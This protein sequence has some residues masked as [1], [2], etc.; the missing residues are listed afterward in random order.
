MDLVSESET[1]IICSVCQQPN[2]VGTRF[3]HH[4]WGAVLHAGC[5]M[6]TPRQNESRLARLKSQQRAKLITISLLALITLASIIFA[7][8]YYLTDIV[9]A[10]PQAV[11]SDSLPGEW[12]MFRH[13]L[14]RSGATGISGI[15]PQGKL[16]WVFATGAPIH[17][18]PAVVDGTVYVGSQDGKLYA[19]DA[20]SGDKRWE[21]QTGSWVQS[22]PT[23]ANG[24]VYFGSNDGRMYALSADSGEK[25]WDFKTRYPVMSSPAVADGIVYFGSED[26]YLYALDAEKGTKLWDFQTEGYVTSSPV[27]ANGI[28]YSGSGSQFFY[29][30]DSRNG[31]LRLYFKTGFPGIYSPAVSGQ[32]VYFSNNSGFLFAV[33][34][35]ART[36]R[37]WEHEIKPG[38]WTQLWLMGVPGIPPPTPQAGWLWRLRVG[39]A[40]TTSP[41][42]A[43]D[44]LYLG[45]NNKLLAI[46]LQS[47]QKQWE[48]AAGG[49]IR[50][51]PAVVDT[52]IYVGSEDG[53]LYALDATTG[54]KLWD[55]PLGGKITSS[56]AVANGTVYIGSYDGNLYAIE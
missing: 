20:A 12:A 51:A 55:L 5:L 52:T 13:D 16:K 47:Y 11:S 28:V 33:D 45:S 34:G 17:S 19:L 42:I 43:N 6:L 37:W 4:C 56:P 32:T 38:Y 24:A 1:Q 39:S 9:I 18:S 44:T 41:V 10:P 29:S 54:D 53:R 46:D 36:W 48:F 50:S 7:G 25:L 26:Y 15:L 23:I 49:T 22:S 30:L 35:N 27:V 31:R 2:L 14:T 3:C 21:Y 8:L 40:A